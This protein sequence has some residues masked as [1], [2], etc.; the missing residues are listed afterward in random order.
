MTAVR[1]QLLHKSDQ[2][3]LQDVV[4][5]PLWYFHVP[6]SAATGQGLSKM[7]AKIQKYVWG[8]PETI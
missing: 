1:G 5:G 7:M 4:R 6:T 2:K 8:K 3:R